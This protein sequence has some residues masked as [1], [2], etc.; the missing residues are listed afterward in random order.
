[1]GTKIVLN[2]SNVDLSDD[3]TIQL[4][5]KHLDHLGWESISGQVTATL[6]ARSADVVG[7]AVGVADAIERHLPH[8]SVVRVDEQLVAVS[9]IAARLGM[10]REGVRLWVQGK[11][12]KA[13]VPFPFPRGQVSHGNTVMKIWAWPDVLFWM[14][15]QYQIDPEVG[16]SYPSDRDVAL[17]NAAIHGRARE[18]K[19]WLPT[20]IPA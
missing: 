12:R 11:R 15:S 20:S 14:R 1:M 9:D 8:A 18:R 4:L 7:E 2:V 10:T 5:A 17:L 3:P 13:D 6:Y 16:V 19:E